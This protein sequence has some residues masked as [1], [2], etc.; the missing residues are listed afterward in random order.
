MNTGE[1]N[2]V[3]PQGL[4]YNPS[5]GNLTYGNNTII[6]T[7]RT[8]TGLPGT[9]GPI[10]NTGI[11]NIRSMRG[12]DDIQFTT[13]INFYKGALIVLNDLCVI[14]DEDLEEY[15]GLLKNNDTVILGINKLKSTYESELSMIYVKYEQYD[16][17]AYYGDRPIFLNTYLRVCYNHLI[18]AFVQTSLVNK[19]P[20]LH[21]LRYYE[22][23]FYNL[24]KKIHDKI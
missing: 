9:T 1:T 4:I 11:G 23:D 17:N 5:T 16:A 20:L 14:S 19:V 3:D 12:I 6:N 18:T 22:E 15:N 8:K 2:L 7:G 10:G 24:V 21:S 13:H